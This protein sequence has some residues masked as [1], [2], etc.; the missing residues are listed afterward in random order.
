MPGTATE[1][2]TPHFRCCKTCCPPGGGAMPGTGTEE[3]AP[4]TH[5]RD[6]ERFWNRHRSPVGTELRLPLWRRSD[7]A[8][9]APGHWLVLTGN[10]SRVGSWSALSVVYTVRSGSGRL[11][12][13]PR[14]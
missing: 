2:D 8:S 5:A 6:G 13:R 14:V 10:G 12:E 9:T 4:Q 1:E 7:T 3:D 11:K